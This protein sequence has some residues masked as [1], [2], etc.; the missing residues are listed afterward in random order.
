MKVYLDACALQRPLDDKSR[1]RIATEAEAILGILAL[2]QSGVVHLISS[3][4][5]EYEI[6]RIP[7]PLRRE[8]AIAVLALAQTRVILTEQA[9]RI[10]N[11]FVG[12]GIK[13]LDALHLALA[14]SGGADYFCTCDD[15]L[16][17]RAVALKVLRVA[18]VTPLEL[19]KELEK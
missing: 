14:E 10:A 4:A 6:R 19:I 17:K 5:L 8:H 3:Q 7:T 11:E 16:Y 9:E 2:A 18:V 15:R 1:L 12:Q 13:S